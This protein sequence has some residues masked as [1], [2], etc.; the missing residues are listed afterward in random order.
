MAVNPDPRPGRWLL[1]LVILGMVLFTYVF[2]RTLPGAEADAVDLDNGATSTTTTTAAAADPESTT[3]TTTP[4]DAETAAYLDALNGLETQ[5]TGFQT[6]M[7]T[8]NGQ[9]D[10]SPRQIEYADAEAALAELSG[11][12][13]AWAD[14]AASVTP[15]L[16]LTDSHTLVSQAAEIVSESAAAVLSGLQ[17]PTADPRIA[18]L[19][20]FDAAVRAF[21]ATVDDVE[22]QA[23]SSA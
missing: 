17:A 15:P 12:V 13:G 4:L 20:Q 22:T 2:V 7:S 21:T 6:T 18:A 8:V 23:R 11:E 10:A 1:P 3:T 14:A 19:E 9:W 16:S 5:L